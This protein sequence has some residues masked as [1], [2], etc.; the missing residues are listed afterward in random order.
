MHF[1]A[2]STGDQRKKRNGTKKARN[3]FRTLDI[4]SRTRSLRNSVHSRS[5]SEPKVVP[6]LGGVSVQRKTEQDNYLNRAAIGEQC[7]IDAHHLAY[8]NLIKSNNVFIQFQLPAEEERAY[9]FN[10]IDQY[11]YQI[12]IA[13]W[14]RGTYEI[15]NLLP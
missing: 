5:L 9:Q 7:K 12:Q 15:H 1:Q 3:D 6:S 10:K 2:R 14:K 11:I 8:I 4:H 13:Q